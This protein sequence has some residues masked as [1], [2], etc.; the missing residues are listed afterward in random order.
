MPNYEQQLTTNYGQKLGNQKYKHTTL[1]ITGS[2]FTPHALLSRLFVRQLELVRCRLSELTLRA[3]YVLGVPHLV[4]RQVLQQAPTKDAI[5][6]TPFF[7]RHLA[8][9]NAN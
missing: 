8:S 7:Y 9:T 6:I 4:H 5:L 3:F 1:R 2:I